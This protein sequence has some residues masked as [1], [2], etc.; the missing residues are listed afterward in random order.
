M[1]KRQLAFMRRAYYKNQR[2]YIFM[3]G[4]LGLG[5][6]GSATALALSSADE[7][8]TL[9]ALPYVAAAAVQADAAEEDS[10]TGIVQS[11]VPY[12]SGSVAG[13]RV[14]RLLA[15][16]GDPVV[17]GQPLAVLDGTAAG[18][19]VLQAQAE[20]DRA[21]VIASERAAAAAR[22]AQLTETGTMSAAERAAIDAEARAASSAARAA[23]AGFGLAQDEAGQRIVRASGTGVVAARNIEVGGV[24][25]PGQAL[26]VIEGGGSRQILAA[27]PQ[28]LADKIRPGMPV[29]FSSDGASGAARVVGMS[30][31]VE[32]GGVIP[33]R[34]A[35]TSG[36][37]MPGAIVRL[38]IASGSSEPGIVRVPATAVQV[39]RSGGRF[40]YRI[41]R[42]RIV[43][44][45]VTLIG[46]TGADAR[47]TAALP[48]GARVVEA[49]G[50]FVRA[51]QRVLIAKP[52]T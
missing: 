14:V 50:A 16:I 19:R 44:V 27:V 37:P 47:I 29:R 17:A 23:R 38:M 5:V 1:T 9:E 25:A 31:R 7:K 24:A 20:V 34:L 2:S 41:D 10:L 22:A 13:G 32:D 33:V 48:V 28:K 11:T 49:G 35:I 36:Q 3:G 6:L 46:L 26:F 39:Q 52:G 4:V 45:P 15:Q 21:S 51:G 8:K 40:V 12:Q 30:S 18:L 42:E 43:R